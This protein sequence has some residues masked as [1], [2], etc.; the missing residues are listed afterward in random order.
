MKQILQKLWEE[1]ELPL[2]PSAITKE[3]LADFEAEYAIRLPA[4]LQPT[5]PP[6][7]RRPAFPYLL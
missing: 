1:A 4:F 2:N 6:I 7:C 3:E 5:L